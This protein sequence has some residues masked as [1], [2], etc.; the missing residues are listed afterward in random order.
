MTQGYIGFV[1]QCIDHK[2][3]RVIALDVKT[4][5]RLCIKVYLDSEEYS[6]AV[7]CHDHNSPVKFE[8]EV[9]VERYISSPKYEKPKPIY[10]IEET[11]FFLPVDEDM[12]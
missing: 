6:N 8:G 3:V 1:T 10:C 5:K 2:Y 9:V 7:K 11:V 12:F 4:K